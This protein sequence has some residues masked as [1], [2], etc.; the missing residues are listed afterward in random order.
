MISRAAGS[1]DSIGQ[2]VRGLSVFLMIVLKDEANISVLSMS[3]NDITALYPNNDNFMQ[4]F[5]ET[6]HRYRS[7]RQICMKKYGNSN[8]QA[9]VV[10]SRSDHKEKNSSTWLNLFPSLSLTYVF[11]AMFKVET[12]IYTLKKSRLMLLVTVI[13]KEFRDIQLRCGSVSHDH[14]DDLITSS[15]V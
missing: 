9:G 1:T 2:A 11:G 3:L 8:D 14:V 15:D 12:M 13:V 7:M 4:L 10:T 5:P 6:R